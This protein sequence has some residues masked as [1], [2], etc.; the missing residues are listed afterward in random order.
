[1]VYHCLCPHGCS[2][3]TAPSGHHHAI[4]PLYSIPCMVLRPHT[5]SH[6]T[7]CMQYS[8]TSSP[9]LPMVVVLIA[10]MPPSLPTGT[11]YTLDLIVA[12]GIS[13][14]SLSPHTSCMYPACPCSIALCATPLFLCYARCWYLASVCLLPY[15]V[16]T[17]H[18]LSSS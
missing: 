15:M 11:S 16:S 2:V 14:Q 8:I 7:Y 4:P 13:F 9:V 10:T 6:C 3:Y 12:I 17:I 1:M 5:T 18:L